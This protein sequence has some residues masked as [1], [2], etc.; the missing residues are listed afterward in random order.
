MIDVRTLLFA[1][2]V[3]FAILAIAMILVWRGNRTFPGL[4]TL[5]RVHV[6]MIPGAALIGLKPGVIPSLVSAGLGNALVVLSVIWLLEG[7]RELYGLQRDR[8]PR[9]AFLAWGT[10]L[11][12][13]L[14]VQDSLRGR[15][16]VTSC[17]ALAVLL[18][19]AWSALHGLRHPVDGAPSLLIAGSVGLLAASFAARCVVLAT[20]SSVVQ[21][22]SSDTFTITLLTVSLVA[23]TGWTLGV[24]NLVYGRLNAEL[25]RDVLARKRSEEALE[26][27]VQIA[28]H[29]LRNPLTSIFGTL[30][31]LS[32][33]TLHLSDEER[34]HLLHIA[35]RNSAR[36]VRL[37]NDLLDLERAESGQVDLKIEMVEIDPLLTQARELSEG[38]ARRHG[39]RIELAPLP[40]LRISA[41][42][43]RLQQVLANLISN[44]VKF[45]RAG[46]VVRLGASRVRGMVRVEVSDHG[47]GIPKD[48]Q[49][50]IF[51][52]FSRGE[53]PGPSEESGKG[54]GLGLA[55]SKALIEGMGGRIGFETEDRRGTTFYFELPAAAPEHTLV[56]QVGDVEIGASPA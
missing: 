19:A 56:A 41:D 27:V 8:W 53:T 21:A 15:I 28:A 13:F 51:Q 9:L 7:I 32:A 29:E 18:R 34:E 4:A 12:F 35:Q 43:Q 47:P 2:A 6:T 42:P 30:Q 50:R 48:F 3:V 54:S 37:V 55:I 16:L 25:S 44:A 26:Q 1:N 17:V 10:G 38:H 52:R 45:S 5:A 23:G 33:P 22:L 24:M 14:Y 11:L 40:P 39:V 20:A 31:L 46:G 36:M 49:H